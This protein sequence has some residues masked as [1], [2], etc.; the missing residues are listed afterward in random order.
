VCVSAPLSLSLA[1]VA[2]PLPLPLVVCLRDWCPP[3][4]SAFAEKAAGPEGKWHESLLF[5]FLLKK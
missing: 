2:L 5:C 1:S 3:F 4:I